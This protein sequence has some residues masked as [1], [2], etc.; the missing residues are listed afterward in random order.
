MRM[1]SLLAALALAAA[2]R[3]WA[4]GQDGVQKKALTQTLQVFAAD[5]ACRATAATNRV[6]LEQDRDLQRFCVAIQTF[7]RNPDSVAAQAAAVAAL[8]TNPQVV[9]TAPAVAQQ[10]AAADAA[11]ARGSP[12]AGVAIPTVL[13]DF[14]ITRAWQ[15][16]VQSF[17]SDVAKNLAD[18]SKVK[19]L[20]PSTLK[21]LARLDTLGYRALL[22]ALRASFNSDLQSLPKNITDKAAGFF[23]DGVPVWAQAAAAFTDP[24]IA[25]VQGGSPMAALASLSGLSASQVPNADL[26]A[27]LQLIGNLAARRDQRARLG[28]QDIADPSDAVYGAIVAANVGSSQATERDVDPRLGDL[29]Q[30]IKRESQAETRDEDAS[31]RAEAVLGAVVRV[32]RGAAHGNDSADVVRAADLADALAHALANHDWSAL[33]ASVLALLPDNG[34]WTR[35]VTLGAALASAK[36]GQ[37]VSD[38]LT[39]AADPVGSF[40]ARRVGGRTTWAVVAYF[41]GQAGGEWLPGVTSGA[42]VGVEAA[43]ALPIGVEVAW[44]NLPHG[45]SKFGIFFSVLNLGTLAS[46]RLSHLNFSTDTGKATV[47]GEPE[48]SLSQLIAPGVSLT[49]GVAK[50]PLTFGLGAEYVRRLRDAPGRG[51]LNAVRVSAFIGLDLT[52]FRF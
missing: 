8:T 14:L 49:M 34:S 39:A 1:T 38:A 50:I 13:T 40:R 26:L 47:N 31:Q 23:P 12:D 7:V 5:S 24:F 42:S 19:A 9:A 30:V 21:L 11:Q 22:P 33:A 6:A 51:P 36:S 37:E 43:V 27:T 25:I 41:G 32:L 3:V 29:V 28:R 20:L 15:E 48:G 17:F 16:M 44:G 10:L 4:Q 45:I 52:L 35:L 46:Y 2:T 18:D